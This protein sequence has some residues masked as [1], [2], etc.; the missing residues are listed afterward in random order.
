MDLGKLSTGQKIFAVA[1]L[2]YFIA[3][4]LSWYSLDTELEGF[5]FDF[6]A[7]AWDLGFLWGT[8]W[9]L[10]FLAGA[11]LIVLPAFGVSAPKLPAIAFL[12]VGALATLFT[13]LKLLIGED[14]PISASF[15]IYLA[16]IAAIA[17]A[18]GGFMMFT[19]SGGNINDLKDM[20][21]IKGSFQGGGGSSPP[22]PPPPGMT[23]P[24]PPPPPA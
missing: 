3:S 8:L 22:P 17:A 21:K 24:P 20:N 7:N 16:V 11:V 10:L 9:A 1:G 19:E 4:F 15:G 2:V 18:Y 13:L 14:D 23:P 12:A 6:S 5:G